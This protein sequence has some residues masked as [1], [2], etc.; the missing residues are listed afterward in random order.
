MYVHI[1]GLA[2]VSSLKCTPIEYDVT[3]V[4]T[5]DDLYSSFH[6]LVHGPKNKYRIHRGLILCSV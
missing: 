2:R 4:M 1:E 3:S 6:P 5:G